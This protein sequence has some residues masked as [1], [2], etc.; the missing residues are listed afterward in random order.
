MIAFS[1]SL[2]ETQTK[3]KGSIIPIRVKI[4]ACPKIP[5]AGC[6]YMDIKIK[7]FELKDQYLE[8]LK[9]N[10][11][12]LVL[13][14]SEV[15][16]NDILLLVS[17][18]ILEK[19]HFKVK[20]NLNFNNILEVKYSD[21]EENIDALEE[22]E[23][24]LSQFYQFDLS[25]Y[26]ENDRSLSNG[27][28]N[29]KIDLNHLVNQELEQISDVKVNLDDEESD[30]IKV[31]EPEKLSKDWVDYSFNNKGIDGLIDQIRQAWECITDQEV[32]DKFQEELFELLEEAQKESLD[33]CDSCEDLLNDLLEGNS[34][35]K[36]VNDI[37][38][39]LG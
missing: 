26:L 1:D 31:A 9:Q 33:P 14:K 32:A 15:V 17:E 4:F 28:I 23:D 12:K 16:D 19:Y 10:I 29:L 6:K 37:Y 30:E 7:F 5:G 11:L 18:Y 27:V 8:S 20:L 36:W 25:N 22:I 38:E 24:F 35:Q 39:L 13:E 34:G 21:F 2:L 3:E